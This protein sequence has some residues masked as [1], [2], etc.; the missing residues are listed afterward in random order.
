M[1]LTDLLEPQQSFMSCLCSRNVVFTDINSILRYLARVAA[2]AG[3]YGAN[4]MEHAEVRTAHPLGC[5]LFF[6]L[7]FRSCENFV[8][9]LDYVPLFSV[10]ILTEC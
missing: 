7:C 1:T 8:S 2:T 3:L 9:L 5:V 10:R 4:L 6:G